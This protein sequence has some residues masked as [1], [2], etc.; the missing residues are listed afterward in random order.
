MN[1]SEFQV[2]ADALLDA[3]PTSSNPTYAIPTGSSSTAF[4]R[5][6]GLS[7]SEQ[8]AFETHMVAC[9]NCRLEFQLAQTIRALYRRRFHY[10]QAPTDTVER[11]HRALEEEYVSLVGGEKQMRD[12]FD[13]LV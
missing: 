10:R 3:Q 8:A 2:K 7:E 1:C 4:F 11:V 5:R 9:N 13:W 6:G 12:G